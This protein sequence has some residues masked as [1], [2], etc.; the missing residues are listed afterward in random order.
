MFILSAAIDAARSSIPTHY[1]RNS[2]AFREATFL[3]L[4]I[5]AEGAV[6]IDFNK[7]PKQYRDAYQSAL[8]TMTM[9][10]DDVHGKVLLQQ[11]Q[12]VYGWPLPRDVQ[13]D[14]CHEIS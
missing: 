6:M 8:R 11:C 4:R 2:G 10:P 5:A 3:G 13:S 14:M 7:V 12:S 9:A 1:A